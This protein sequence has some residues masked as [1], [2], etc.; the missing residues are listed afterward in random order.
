M[1]ELTDIRHIAAP[2]D[3]ELVVTGRFERRVDVWSL[4]TGR[5][6]VGFDTVLDFGGQRLA[7]SSQTGICLAAAHRAQ[8][9]AA[10]GLADGRLIWRRADLE[11]IQQITVSPD[12]RTAYCCF[13]DR[14]CEVIAVAQ[15]RT[16]RTL[17]GV[18]R[19]WVD[20]FLSDRLEQGGEAEI[21]R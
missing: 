15:G 3:G 19:L 14:P 4:R 2:Y 13:D 12:G 8:G 1:A 6:L 16:V 11:G 18:R 20:P 5:S 17:H 7:L 10:Y 21:P 9:V